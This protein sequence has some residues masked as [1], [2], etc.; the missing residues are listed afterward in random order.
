MSFKAEFKLE[1]LKFKHDSIEDFYTL[2]C[3]GVSNHLWLL[4]LLFALYA[5][6]IL[7]HSAVAFHTQYWAIF[8]TQ[9]GHV[10]STIYLCTGSALSIY[11]T[12][13][14][15]N[16]IVSNKAD[17]ELSS[18]VT[19]MHDKVV[20][21]EISVSNMVPKKVCFFWLVANMSYVI[22]G[23]IIILYWGFV[24][25]DHFLDGADAEFANINLHGVVYGLVV[26]DFLLSGIPIRILH[27]VYP[28]LFGLT[29]GV[30]SAIFTLSTKR[31]IYPVLKWHTHAIQA[32]IFSLM[33]LGVV[34]VV[35]IFFY[36]AHRLKRR[37]RSRTMTMP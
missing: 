24:H 10:V 14:K 34:I 28:V 37:V 1:K 23:L 6:A 35:Q 25:Q 21:R 17:F 20:F 29:Y 9:W 2:R 8:L 32:L 3:C 5:L 16:I 18:P 30:F 11:Y 22:G 36:G 33:A 4:R 7:I 27:G 15:S 13:Q 12:F 26:I 19:D 31:A